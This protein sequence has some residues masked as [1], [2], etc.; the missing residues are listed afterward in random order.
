M[1]RLFQEFP[2]VAQKL[3]VTAELLYGQHGVDGVSLRQIVAAAGQS[4]NNA[5][6]LH[7]GSK[8][9]LIQAA[10]EMRLLPLEDERGVLLAAAHRDNDLSVERMLGLLLMPLVTVM[11]EHDLEHYARF[12]LAVMKVEPEEHPFVKSADI[13]PASMEIHAQLA[14]SLPHLPPDVFRRR[15]ALAC[16]LFLS[17][18]AQVGGKLRLSSN[19]Y[20]SRQIFF[21]DMF[22]ASVAV[23]TAPFPP[24][25]DP[26]I[27][28]DPE[29][30]GA[31]YLNRVDAKLRE[32][33]AAS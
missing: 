29:A 27:H 21:Q 17:A 20:P 6:P 23:L 10:S 16:S 33:L 15:L 26:D 22:S 9:G 31:E 11:N 19:G 8:A 18:A 12:T 32:R 1:P 30:G 24:G 5:V 7:F 28:M 14:A 3:M 25:S 13:S 4:N 2:P